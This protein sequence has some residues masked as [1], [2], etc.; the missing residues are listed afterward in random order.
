[1]TDDDTHLTTWTLA[2]I[3]SSGME[4]EG[5]CVTPGC[6]EFARFDVDRLIDRFGGEWRVPKILPVRC[7]AC[8]EPLHF[9]L[10]VLHD[11]PPAQ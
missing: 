11:D 6:N 8:G 5:N 3:K 9:Q 10:A 1:M 2:S 7:S 4:L